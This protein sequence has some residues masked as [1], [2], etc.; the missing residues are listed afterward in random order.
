[1]NDS[2]TR[3]V[4]L[5]DTTLRE[6]GQA[7]GVNLDAQAKVRLARA[8]VATGAYAIEAGYPMTSPGEFE[9]VH[10]VAGEVGDSVIVAALARANRI[11]VTRANAALAGA[12]RPRITVFVQVSEIQAR[13]AG[14]TLDQMAQRAR[15]SVARARDLVADVQ[16]SLG[17]VPRARPG[18]V[19]ELARAGAEAGAGT[20]SLVDSA[21]VATPEEIGRAVSGVREALAGLPTAVSVH[22]HDDLGLATANAFA[23]VLAGADQV[24]CSVNG[25]GERAGNTAL[26]EIA[27]LLRVKGPAHGVDC[28]VHPADLAPASAV[29]EQATGYSVS[30]NKAVVG[31]HAFVHSAGVH[32]DAVLA[33]DS[34]YGALGSVFGAAPGLA[35]GKHTSLAGLRAALAA[36]G[37]AP[38]TREL[39]DAYRRLK[40]LADAGRSP[41]TLADLLPAADSGR[42]GR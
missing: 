12:A 25:V 18:F 16:L 34:S 9:A 29:V 39:A 27:V 4:A 36:S 24:E 11:D 22:C 17:D 28:A 7:P 31:R 20:I 23:A 21:G 1:M 15:E 42:S 26:E 13:A 40:E 41:L 32:Q 10:A 3:Q 5:Y 33:D 8:L 6:G 2:D 37:A 14:L 30:W 38:T 19:A 35:L